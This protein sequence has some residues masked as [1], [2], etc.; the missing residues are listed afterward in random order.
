MFDLN[1]YVNLFFCLWNKFKFLW[2]RTILIAKSHQLF[3]FSE[4]ET[5][6]S[7]W[8]IDSTLICEYDTTHALEVFSNNMRFYSNTQKKKSSLSIVANRIWDKACVTLMWL[9]VNKTK[10]NSNNNNNIDI[11]DWSSLCAA[12]FPPHHKFLDNQ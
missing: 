5:R 7:V 9:V 8:S 6:S 10:N 11:K 12:N 3:R 2:R 1:F 4:W